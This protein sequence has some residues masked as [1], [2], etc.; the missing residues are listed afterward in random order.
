VVL[1]GAFLLTAC[2]SQ[3]PVKTEIVWQKTDG[4]AA[5]R[6]ELDAAAKACA[7]ET[8]KTGGE[9][10]G[11]FAHVEWSVHMLDCMKRKG[12]ERT[13]KPVPSTW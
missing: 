9:G 2:S 8:H 7:A 11:R 4:S 12:Y 1:V 6:E 5:T 3:K 10:T 13:E